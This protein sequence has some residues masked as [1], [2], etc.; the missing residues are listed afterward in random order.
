MGRGHLARLLKVGDTTWYA[1]AT[2]DLVT[3][4]QMARSTDL[5][6]W[7]R[8]GD[9]QLRFQDCRPRV[10]GPTDTPQETA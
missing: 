3:N 6:R 9:A 2:G 8:L 10:D 5:V 4:R 1:D 7:E